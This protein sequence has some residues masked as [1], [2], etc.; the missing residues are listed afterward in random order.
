VFIG[1][2]IDPDLSQHRLTMGSVGRNE[3]LSGDFPISAAA[4]GLAIEREDEFFAFGE[5]GANPTGEG[6]LQ[7]RDVQ[8]AKDFAEGGLGRSFASA[9]AQSKGEGVAFVAS[10][11][12][13]GL[14]GA[15]SGKHGK[16][17]K[18]ENGREGVANAA[19]FAR[20]GDFGKHFEKGK[21]DSH[22]QSL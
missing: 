6:I 20:V 10:E 19:S 16:H 15:C 13:D 3:M 1:L 18:G 22:N 8:H 17:G 21:R 5:T 9:K 2:G 11:L 14:I 12:S 7:S 4:S